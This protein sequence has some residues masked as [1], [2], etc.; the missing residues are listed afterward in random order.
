MARTMATCMCMCMYI[1]ALAWLSRRN[2]MRSENV[3]GSPSLAMAV[4]PQQTNHITMVTHC[5][6]NHSLGDAVLPTSMGVL[7]TGAGTLA[8]STEP[9]IELELVLLSIEPLLPGPMVGTTSATF[10]CRASF[11]WNVRC[12]GLDGFSSMASG[13]GASGKHTPHS[14]TPTHHITH[15]IPDFLQSA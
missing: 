6:G 14:H 1:P 13:T 10:L 2:A 5:H 7:F 9:K 15:S 12:S 8:G 4:G 11:S 3:D